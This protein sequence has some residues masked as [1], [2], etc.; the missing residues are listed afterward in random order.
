MWPSFLLVPLRMAAIQAEESLKILIAI[1]PRI[2]V[3]VGSNPK[4]V[5]RQSFNALIS[6]SAVEREM[7]PC[8]FDLWQST[9]TLPNRT[10]TNSTT[11]PEVLLQLGS[12]AKSASGYAQSLRLGTKVG[13]CYLLEL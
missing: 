8:R 6:A 3:T 13:N 5:D 12:P 1:S 4:H 7:C 10:P 2:A 11:Y 9:E